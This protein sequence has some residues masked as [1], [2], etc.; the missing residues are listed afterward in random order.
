ML[1]ARELYTLM[2]IDSIIPKEA[3]CYSIYTKLCVDAEGTIYRPH[4][5][6]TFGIVPWFLFWLWF[7]KSDA[8]VTL[9]AAQLISVIIASVWMLIAPI[10]M[11]ISEMYLRSTICL[12]ERSPS[13]H[14]WNVSQIVSG[15][16][17]SNRLYWPIVILVT[18]VFSVGFFLAQDFM[19]NTLNLEPLNIQMLILG[20]F[21]MAT[22][23]FASGNGVWGVWKVLFLYT[24]I[25]NSSRLAWYPLRFHQI[26]GFERLT[27]FALYSAT[28]FSAGS[29]FAPVVYLSFRDSTGATKVFALFGLLILMFGSTL[30]FMVPSYYLA[31]MAS[32]SRELHLDRLATDI[33]LILSKN[34]YREMCE[35]P[36]PAVPESQFDISELLMLREVLMNVPTAAK[37]MLVISRMCILIAVPFIVGIVPA[38]LI[39]VI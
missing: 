20:M 3:W 14:G 16:C 9:D 21:C 26:H 19:Q 24:S 11:V 30:L 32:R 17:K 35:T 4:I 6:I 36:Y 13:R 33:E 23:G 5:L 15:L 25:A 38:I 12:L 34:E 18:I 27:T 22:T 29:L 39:E 10:L 28:V 1:F 31:R 2:K 37:P 7:W 8:V